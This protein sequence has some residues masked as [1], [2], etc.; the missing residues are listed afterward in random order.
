MNELAAFS[1]RRAE[2]EADLKAEAQRIRARNEAA[3][4]RYNAARKKVGPAA[5]GDYATALWAKRQG[6]N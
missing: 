6:G 5:A 3:N 1:K 2:V 4:K